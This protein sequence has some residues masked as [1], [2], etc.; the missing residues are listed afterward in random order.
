MKKVEE[1]MKVMEEE[2]LVS[3]IEELLKLATPENVAALSEEE[4]QSLKKILEKIA[5]D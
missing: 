2:E 4:L 5:E 1:R 3:E